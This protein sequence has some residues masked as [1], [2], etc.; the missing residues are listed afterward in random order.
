MVGIQD[1]EH[2]E[3]RSI[4]KLESW[5]AKNSNSSSGAWIVTYKKNSSNR[6][7]SYDEIVESLLIYGWIDSIPGKVDEFRSKLY[8]SPRK[9]TSAWSQ[10]NKKRIA[11]LISE[12]RMK[13]AG[14]AAVAA[15]KK[16]GAWTQ[17]DSAQTLQVP[18]DLITA[19]RKFPGS[20]KNFGAFPPGVRRQILEWISQAKTAPTRE[21]RIIETASK[22]QENI[23]ANQW[24]R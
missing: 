24:R 3:I 20:A 17:I 8:V 15:A 5:L 19:F 18:K 6:S 7:P 11:K 21:K 14:L 22:A 12:G 16:N 23:R 10:A 9:P 4:A 2:V 13:D 1:R